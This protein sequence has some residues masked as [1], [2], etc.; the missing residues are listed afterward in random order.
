[1]KWKM[2]CPVCKNK[3]ITT[4]YQGWKLETSVNTCENG[5]QWTVLNEKMICPTCGCL[6]GGC[7]LRINSTTND[8]VCGKNHRWQSKSIIKIN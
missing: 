7:A 3:L 2:D 5:H 8:Y 1:M 6:S 4:F